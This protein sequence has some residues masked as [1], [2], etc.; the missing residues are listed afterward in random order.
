LGKH[1]RPRPS[2]EMDETATSV[3]EALWF[4][5]FVTALLVIGTLLAMWMTNAEWGDW[6]FG[7]PQG[8]LLFP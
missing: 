7:V 5:F 6:T 8:Q 2:R 1:S 3:G 4:I